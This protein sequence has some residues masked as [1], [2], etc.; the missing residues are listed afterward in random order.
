MCAAGGLEVF[1]MFQIAATAVQAVG[2]ITQGEQQQDYHNFMAAQAEA[3]AQAEKEAGEV[4]AAKVRRAGIGV[5]SEATAS[6]AA[7]GVE[8]GAGTPMRIHEEIGQRYEADAL[9]EI[10]TGNRGAA[11]LR[12]Q[13]Q[14]E[15]AAGSRAVAAGWRGAFGSVLAGGAE[16]SKGWKAPGAPKIDDMVP[17]QYSLGNRQYG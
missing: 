17:G 7:S 3:D 6:L 15:R 1:Q 10:L 16:V 2:A 11:R 12:Q 8:V 14:I 4:R 5:Q 9:Q 13:A